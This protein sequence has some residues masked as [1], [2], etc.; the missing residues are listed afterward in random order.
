M[1]N[2]PWNNTWSNLRPLTHRENAANRGPNWNKKSGLPLGIYQSYGG[3]FYAAIRVNKKLINLGSSLD[4][5][6]EAIFARKAAEEK[7]FGKAAWNPELCK[8]EQVKVG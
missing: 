8:K 3:K 5:L 6:E 2:D 4:T 7:Y 1:D